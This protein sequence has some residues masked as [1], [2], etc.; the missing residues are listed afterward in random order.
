[1]A[2]REG[3]QWCW[4]GLCVQ[5]SGD[6]CEL[7]R[8][9]SASPCRS[10]RAHLA[11]VSCTCSPIPFVSSCAHSLAT[12]TRCLTRRPSAFPFRHGRSRPGRLLCGLRAHAA[13]RPCGRHAP[14]SGC[15][16]GDVR[17]IHGNGH[18]SRIGGA[19]VLSGSE[20]RAVKAGSSA[21]L[22]G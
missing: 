5:T 9:A 15:H 13:S 17:R 2:V 20:C 1:M 10:S 7:A 16:A 22:S 12:R 19:A 8:R 11:I 14:P 3:S 18:A 21:R 4:C 6:H